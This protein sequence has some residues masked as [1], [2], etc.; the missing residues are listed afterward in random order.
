MNRCLIPLFVLCL[1]LV[2]ACGSEPAPAPTPDAVATQVAIEKAVAATLTAGAPTATHTPAPTPTNT[3]TLTPSLTPTVTN[4]PSPEPTATPMPLPVLDA[5]VSLPTCRLTVD[6]VPPGFTVTLSKTLDLQQEELQAE[7]VRFVEH[8]TGDFLFG[9]YAVDQV[10][11]GQ[12]AT[13]IDQ[14]MGT[15]PGEE[16][17]HRAMIESLDWWSFYG[18]S[19]PFTMTT[20]IGDEHI[21]FYS[22]P[23]AP[24]TTFFCRVAVRY[25]AGLAVLWL[26]EWDA[27]T[28]EDCEA[29]AHRMDERIRECTSR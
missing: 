10:V 26:K 3:S 4:T 24:E 28:I 25:G 8:L 27:L 14:T 1:L 16:Q 9:I 6:D 18:F 23:R 2:S 22:R 19:E 21:G 20:P 7:D 5:D 29:F 12:G 13:E 17:A 11:Y 15:L